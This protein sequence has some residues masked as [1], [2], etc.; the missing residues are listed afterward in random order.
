M[1]MNVQSSHGPVK[2]A[3]IQAVIIRKNGDRIELGRICYY[4][5]NPLRRWAWELANWFKRVILR[6]G[7]P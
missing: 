6:R 2:Q 7:R 1:S 4:H 5:K 3:E